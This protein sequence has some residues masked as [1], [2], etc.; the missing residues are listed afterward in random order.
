MSDYKPK[1]FPRDTTSEEPRQGN[2]SIIKREVDALMKRGATDYN[3]LQQLRSKHR[4]EE[5]VNAIFDNFKDRLRFVTKKANKFKN[6]IYQ[7]YA[8]KN[9][10]YEEL[11]RKAKRYAKKYELTD[12]EFNMF[13]HLSLT[14]KGISGD[15]AQ[16]PTTDMAKTL[17]YDAIALNTSKLNVKT[18]E[19]EVVNEIIRLYNQ[20]RALHSNV[21]L[22]S[23][24]YRDCAPEAIHGT[25]D[26]KAD[27]HNWYSYV[28][29]VVAALF[30]PK[31]NFLDEQM[32]IAN[33]GHIVKCKFE[34]QALVT[35]PDFELY[36]NLIIDPNE[37]VCHMNSP[38]KDLSNRFYL[39]TKLWDAVL[40]LRQGKYY[41]DRLN[42]FMLT[43]DACRNNIYDAPDLTYVKDEGTILR[44]LLA[45]FSLRPTIVSTSRLYGLMGNVGSYSNV[46]S[47]PLSAAGI[48]EVTTV[49]MV[50]LRLPINITN[51]NQAAITL[52]EALHQPQWFIENKMIVP[53][54]QAIMHSRDVLFFYV[55]RRFQH[56]NLRNIRSPFNF[57]NLPMTV[58]GWE[59][60]NDRPV[61]FQLKMPILN[62]TY[63]LRSVVLVERSESHKNLI[64]GCTAAIRVPVDFNTGDYEPT[65]FM[66]DP[67][68]AGEM[69][70]DNESNYVRNHPITVIP[71]QDSFVT[72]SIDSFYKR[73][74]TRGTIFM[75]QKTS[76]ARFLDSTGIIATN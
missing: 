57:D 14:D 2:Q 6:L 59:A 11:M 9:L 34:G 17:G 61:N 48:T 67:Q 71:E 16:L 12:D 22:Q 1:N 19:I 26:F 60:L 18:N 41:N 56:L 76:G 50:N 23:L 5:L 27:K 31:I 65:V 46:G 54:S 13:W 43:I 29:P 55:G 4:D 10:P 70:K 49:P 58:T 7:R 68:G 52:E 40:N 36:W 73:A 53:K 45:A 25:V 74:S 63:E 44:R 3:T 51:S 8:P 72:G 62:D 24:M 37:R 21:V 66:Y 38:I 69:F 42:D 75:Y 15:I 33:L 47:N 39:Q 30:L 64:V 28:H 35:K 20:T 32:L